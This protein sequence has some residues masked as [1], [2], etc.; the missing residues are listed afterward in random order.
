MNDNEYPYGQDPT[1]YPYGQGDQRYPYGQPPERPT[2]PYGGG[3]QTPYGG[4][5]SPYGGGQSP[6]GGGPYGY[7]PRPP[8]KPLGQRVRE[9]FAD[10]SRRTLMLLGM[11]AGTGVLLHLLLL[12]Y[13]KITCKLSMTNSF[14]IITSIHKSIFTGVRVGKNITDP[15]CTF[16]NDTVNV[17]TLTASGAK[18]N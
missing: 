12:N 17:V 4:G 16:S 13:L 10:P 3:G 2:Y 9:A 11:A 15:F 8:K 6:Y 18:F 5:Q 14:F 7:A 1:R